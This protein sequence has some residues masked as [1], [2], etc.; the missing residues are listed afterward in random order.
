MYL[1][2]RPSLQVSGKVLEKWVSSTCN[3]G[4]QKTRVCEGHGR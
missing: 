3:G 1:V 2:W 4:E